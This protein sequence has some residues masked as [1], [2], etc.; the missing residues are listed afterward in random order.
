MNPKPARSRPSSALFTLVAIVTAVAAL[1]LAREILL[2]LALATFFSFL[3]A[4]LADRLERWRLGRIPSV[5]AVVSVA[6]AVLGL[7]GWVVTSQLVD[8][9]NQLPQYRENIIA[10]SRRMKRRAR[11]AMRAA[12]RLLRPRRGARRKA[13]A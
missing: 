12:K 9:S 1:H 6:F 11:K 3:L 4:P 2:P 10:R 13:M 7:L 8:L 5:L